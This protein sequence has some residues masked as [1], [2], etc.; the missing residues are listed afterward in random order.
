MKFSARYIAYVALLAA[1]SVILNTLTIT[2]PGSG[3]AVSFTYIPT[4]IAGFFFGPA[5]GFFVGFVGDVLGCIIWPKGPWLPLITLASSLM[6]VIPGL[7]RYL[8]LNEK[9]LLAISFVTTFVVC[10]A[11][12]NTFALWH[13][14]ASTKKTFWVYLVARLPLQL[15]VMAVN[16]VLC[17]V[18]MPFFKKLIVPRLVKVKAV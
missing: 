15:T 12:F 14:Y 3:F 4:Y 11:G 17:F 10:S 16:L 2:M 6:G 1:V 18:L 5:A 13:A 8:P 7:I 9:I